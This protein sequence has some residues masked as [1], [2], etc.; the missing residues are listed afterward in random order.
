MVVGGVG[1][2]TASCLL[3]LARLNREEEKVRLNQ[4]NQ[5]HNGL[6]KI[7]IDEKYF[8]N[9]RKPESGIPANTHGLR[10]VFGRI[11]S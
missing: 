4:L 6:R 3:A 7:E 9:G 2:A 11:P 10:V 8:V 1:V 5:G